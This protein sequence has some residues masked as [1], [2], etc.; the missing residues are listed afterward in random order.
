MKNVEAKSEE[1]NKT[2][3]E[4]RNI[5][6]KVEELVKQG[7]PP[8]DADGNIHLKEIDTKDYLRD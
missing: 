4:T 8:V 7:K 5:L 6:E 1:I 2:L 3:E